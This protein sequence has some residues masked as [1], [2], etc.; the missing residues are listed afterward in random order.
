MTRGLVLISV[1][2]VSLLTSPAF[3]KS[4]TAT[5]DGTNLPSC[6]PILGTPGV[7]VP[8]SDGH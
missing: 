6:S 1:F 5:L 7:L 8:S 4:S 2:S 3:A